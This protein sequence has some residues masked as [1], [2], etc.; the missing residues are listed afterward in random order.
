MVLI[1]I[2]VQA[3]YV[4]QTIVKVTLAGKMVSRSLIAVR[5]V[6][7]MIRIIHLPLVDVLILIVN[8]HRWTQ[9]HILIVLVTFANQVLIL[10]A[11]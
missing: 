3:W 7:T 1:Q 10:V 2:V 6:L 5:R 11:G 4:A 9:L 8:V